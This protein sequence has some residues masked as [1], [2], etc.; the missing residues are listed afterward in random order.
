MNSFFYLF[1]TKIKGSIRVQFSSLGT[2]MAVIFM[3]LIYGVLIGTIFTSSVPYQPETMYL[4]TAM[5][6]LAGVGVTAFFSLLSLMSKRKA[7][8]YDTDAF[9]FFSGPYTKLQTN[10][11]ILV[12]TLKGA[13]GYGLLGC[14]F[15]G[16]LSTGRYFSIPYFLLCLLVFFLISAVFLLMTDYIYMWTLVKPKVKIWNYIAV[17]LVLTAVGA[18][19]SISMQAAGYD[20]KDGFLKFAV[21][22]EFYYVPFFGW[23]KLVLSAFL[24]K[25]YVGMVIG[26]A[27]LLVANA[28][29]VILFLTFPRNIVEQA[30]RDAEEISNY[31]RR[32]KANGGN[33]LSSEGKIK[34]VRGEFPEGARAIFYKNILSMKKTGSFLRKQDFFIIIVY[35]VLSYVIAP[36]SRFYM[37]SYMMIL[38]LFNL[39]NDSEFLGEL[40]NYQI[41]LIPENPLKKLIYVILPAYFK[42]AILIG[43]AILIAGIFNRMPVLTILQYF[44]MLLGYAMI[45]ISGTV[46]ATKIMKTKASVALENLLRMLIILLA[47][48]PATGVGFLAWFLLRDL[49]IFQIVVTVITI[50]MN[51][52]VSV[53]ILIACQGMMNGREI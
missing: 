9:Y 29:F 30:V 40:K 46:W 23:G 26:L 21:S 4:Q 10:L 41:Y 17:I 19:F 53:I 33:A 38:W 51:F 49:Y 16:L 36:Q 34:Q 18:V 43:T 35:F 50:V 6:I 15:T 20:F 45:F 48:I 8:L 39:L 7:L 24:G 32:V 37:F 14:F 2:G 13:L 52:L 1:R 5:A 27:L 12:Q 42:V 11:F 3:V 44:F 25:E 28:V 47:A 31:V 22:R